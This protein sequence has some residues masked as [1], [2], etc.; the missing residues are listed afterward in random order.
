LADEE[1][2]REKAK[3]LINARM[4]SVNSAGEEV[5]TRCLERVKTAYRATA[6]P[7]DVP[8]TVVHKIPEKELISRGLRSAADNAQ[9]EREDFW[10]RGGR[11]TAKD[12]EKLNSE[13]KE[14]EMNEEKAKEPF[15][16]D[17][18]SDLGL[19]KDAEP[20]RDLVWEYRGVMVIT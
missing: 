18:E 20:L 13:F 3:H 9:K 1:V 11:K 6:A 14:G 4:V 16:K 2:D 15:F 17:F 12:D 10:T 5:N 8:R 7:D 19:A